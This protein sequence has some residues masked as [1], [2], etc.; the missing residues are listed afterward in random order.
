V[1]TRVPL[2][3]KL[4]ILR[5]ADPTRKWQ[6]LDDRRVCILC[7]RVITGRMIDVRRDGHGS[8]HLFCPTPGCSSTPRDW[9]YHGPGFAPAAAV[10]ANHRLR[11]ASA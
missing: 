7:E 5:E 1:N 6:S 9:F 4:L 10:K 8:Y 11:V 2:A 3:E